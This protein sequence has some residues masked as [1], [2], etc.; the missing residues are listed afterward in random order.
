MPAYMIA[1]L[2]INDPEP[3]GPYAAGVTAVTEQYGGRYLFSGPGVTNVEGDW[4]PDGFAIIEFPSREAAMRWYDSPEY[5]PLR[6]LRQAC[7]PTSLV[8]SP[9][10]EA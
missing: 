5:A 9:D 8:L 4:H 6:Q 3:M 2:N 7:G 1:Q 10:V